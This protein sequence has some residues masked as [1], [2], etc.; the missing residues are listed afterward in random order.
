MNCK[1]RFRGKL[2]ASGTIPTGRNSIVYETKCCT[3]TEKRITA[4]EYLVAQI[5]EAALTGSQPKRQRF[6]SLH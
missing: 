6:T 3:K 5:P 2:S 4:E 1:L